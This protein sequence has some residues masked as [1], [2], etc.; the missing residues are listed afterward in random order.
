MIMIQKGQRIFWGKGC[1]IQGPTRL[2]IPA[3]VRGPPKEPEKDEDSINLVS[4]IP[5]VKAL[6]PQ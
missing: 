3:Y 4:R 6:L 2:G 1:K 5:L